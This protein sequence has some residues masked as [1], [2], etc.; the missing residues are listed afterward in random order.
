MKKSRFTPAKRALI[1]WTLFIGLG[2]VFGSYQ[3]LTDPTGKSLHMDAMLPYFQKMPFADLL[4]R[5]YTFSG[6]ALLLVNGLPNLLAAGLMIVGKKLGVLLGGIFGV[7]LMLWICIQFWLFPANPLSISYFLFGFLQAI[8]GIMALIFA[9]QEDFHVC[10]ADYPRIGTNHKRLVVFFSRMG[11]T[12]KKALEEA[13]RTG[14]DIYEVKA[15]E[16]T[17]GT[18]GFWWCGRYGMHRWTMPIEPIGVDL[19][20]YAHVTLCSPI[21]VFR[22]SAPMRSFCRAASGKI[23]EADYILVH[24]QKD[25]YWCAA[26]EM[27]TLLGLTGSPVVSICCREGDYLSEESREGSQ[28]P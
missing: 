3:M 8:T 25:P 10:Q 22:L 17:E 12:R 5:D 16:R 9:K 13:D 18:L 21:W 23:R 1:F 19:S 24:H 28:T 6:I 14:A 4:F 27:D 26:E 2:A 20:Q 11:Y 7:T 15:S